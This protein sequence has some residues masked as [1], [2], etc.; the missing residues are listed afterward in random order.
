MPGGGGTGT[1]FTYGHHTVTVP[2]PQSMAALTEV[3]RYTH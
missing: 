3:G 1:L 2:M